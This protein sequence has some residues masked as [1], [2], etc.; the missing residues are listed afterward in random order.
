MSREF[1]RVLLNFCQPAFIDLGL[2]FEWIS[3]RFNRPSGAQIRFAEPDLVGD[4]LSVRSA[5]SLNFKVKPPQDLSLTIVGAA[6]QKAAV[7][8][9]SSSISQPNDGVISGQV[10]NCEGIS[11][12]LHDRPLDLH[13]FTTAH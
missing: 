3:A 7:R 13:L 4:Q 2:L 1:L 12:T 9:D 11:V 6:A 5:P 8:F 10:A